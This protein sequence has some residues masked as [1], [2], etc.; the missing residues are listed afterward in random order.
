MGI[1]SRPST[2]LREL[3]KVPDESKWKFLMST[4][5]L[6]C[7]KTFSL[8]I[9]IWPYF[10][11]FSCFFQHAL[12]PHWHPPPESLYDIYI[13]SIPLHVLLFFFS[14]QVIIEIIIPKRSAKTPMFYRKIIFRS[15]LGMVVL[16]SSSSTLPPQ[17]INC[18]NHWSSPQ[19]FSFQRSP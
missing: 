17:L 12:P 5:P 3:K 19:S 1:D 15:L 7:W 13:F 8:F 6:S 4:C 2:K 9:G 16:N 10:P 14:Q 11:T 18:C